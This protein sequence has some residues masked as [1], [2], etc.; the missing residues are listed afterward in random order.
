MRQ[1]RSAW[2]YAFQRSIV[3]SATTARFSITKYTPSK[4]FGSSDQMSI[5]R[6]PSIAMSLPYDSYVMSTIG[7][8]ICVHSSATL[9]TGSSA[10][11]VAIVDAGC[12]LT[13][14]GEAVPPALAPALDPDDDV[15]AIAFVD[16]HAS[17]S[18]WSQPNEL[19]STSGLRPLRS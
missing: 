3:M 5:T 4:S 17:F 7:V 9:S 1:S 8:R 13:L 14:L 19:S 15:A 12:A 10:I 18:G 6:W 2:S 11:G 16:L